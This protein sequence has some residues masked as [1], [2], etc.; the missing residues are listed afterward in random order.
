MIH[1]INN[2][3]NEYGFLD[4]EAPRDGIPDGRLNST[5]VRYHP[6]TPKEIH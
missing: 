6:K 5:M 2:W 4:G 1:V 3:G